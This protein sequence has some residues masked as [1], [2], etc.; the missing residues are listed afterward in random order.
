MHSC[1]SH[2]SQRDL[3]EI[4]PKGFLGGIKQEDYKIHMER[5]EVTIRI[6]VKNRNNEKRPAPSNIKTDY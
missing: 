5:K 4:Y 2:C 6:S 1:S 3:F